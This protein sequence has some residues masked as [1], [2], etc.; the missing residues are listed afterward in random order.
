MKEAN[1]LNRVLL[2]HDG[3]SFRI[4]NTD[5]M[6]PYHLLFERFIPM[7]KKEGFTKADIRQMT[8]TNPAEAFVIRI[9]AT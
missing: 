7:L 9:R 3:N 6:R 5:S 8:V 2:S 1:L 4:R